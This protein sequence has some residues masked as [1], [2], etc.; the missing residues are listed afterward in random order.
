MNSPAKHLPIAAF[1]LFILGIKIAFFLFNGS[2]GLW[3][4]SSVYIGMSKYLYSG[5]ESGLWEPS[6]PV[7]WPL[8]LG[9]FWKFG[10]D[11]IF[12]G[13]LLSIF[14]STGSSIVV[15][16]ISAKYFSKKTAFLAALF[17]SFSPSIFLSDT[18][19]L[20]EIISTF[21][22]LLGFYFFL[23]Q[24]NFLS[25]LFLGIS[26]MSRFFQIF[27]ALPVILIYL[28][29]IF[30]KKGAENYK[31]MLAFLIAFSI[32]AVPYIISNIYY[33]GDAF[34]PFS[35]QI[36][37]TKNTGWRFSQPF[38]FYFMGIV[39][40]N[41]LAAFSILGFWL[42]VKGRNAEKKYLFVIF[43]LV[44]ALYVL[45]R[46]K[47]MRLLIP[48]MPFLYIFASHGI[49]RLSKIFRK[50]MIIFMALV[51][52]LWASQAI[53]LLN[54]GDGKKDAQ[55]FRDYL[56][57]SEIKEGIWISSPLFLAASDKKA[58]EL[59]YYPLYNSSRAMSLR[60]KINDAHL[61]MINTCDILPC[62]PSDKNCGK[63]TE[64]FIE[65]LKQN[66]RLMHY[67]VS[68]NCIHVVFEK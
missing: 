67:A 59:I 33:Y 55:E 53:P 35:I 13:K 4:D 19:L 50:G 31:A 18:L 68:G 46:H 24:K 58:E 36:F 52:L 38:S 21:F 40:E 25:G 11:Y 42:A 34:Y 27:F 23:G 66:L 5:G 63:E 54:Q 22:L 57:S 37:M 56:H 9:L 62:P 15:Y 39:R 47:E 17:F 65:A 14:I 12:L 26:F 48:L 51:I 41:F 8:I 10:F 28:F 7:L 49:V 61:V 30:N 3:W 16:L 20:T 60:S 32:P 45:E 43:I 44:F 64:K 1:F 2:A 6:R 29:R